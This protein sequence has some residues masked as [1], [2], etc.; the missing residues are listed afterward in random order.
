MAWR[1]WHGKQFVKT[2][3]SYLLVLFAG[4]LIFSCLFVNDILTKNREQAE[5]RQG[6]TSEN[7]A[8]L[9]DS[10]LENMTSLCG[11]ISRLHWVLKLQ[12]DA[13]SIDA[14]FDPLTRMNIVNDVRTYTSG[15]D[16]YKS[17]LLIFPQQETAISSIGWFELEDY[18]RYIKIKE[19]PLAEQ[20]AGAIDKHHDF[21]VLPT[22]EEGD[23]WLMKTL[24]RTAEPRAHL[25]FQISRSDL[26]RFLLQY[27]PDPLCRM[28]IRDGEG[29]LLITVDR[30]SR[31]SERDRLEERT[32]SAAS[33]DW[34]YVMSF[35]ASKLTVS[36]DS[37]FSL[38]LAVVVCCLVHPVLAY[39]LAS[40]SYR[41]L[42]R[43]LLKLQ[44]NGAGGQEN[45]LSGKVT[46]YQA[47]EQ[48]IDSLSVD[49]RQLR[50][51]ME[52]YQGSVQR[53]VLRQLLQ[54]YF[55]RASLAKRMEDFPF[56][57]T[58][59]TGF[60]VIIV[61]LSGQ[62]EKEEREE[63]RETFYRRRV[64]VILRMEQS[65]D[66]CGLSYYLLASYE[67]GIVII[68]YDNEGRLD[69][70]ALELAAE[71]MRQGEDPAS[72]SSLQIFIGPMER[73]MIGISKS[74]Q[75]A[76]EKLSYS[77][78]SQKMYQPGEFSADAPF[79]YPTDWEIQ[80]INNLK[81]AQLDSTQR[82]INEIREEN[83]RRELSPTACDALLHSLRNTLR[84]V[85]SELNIPNLKAD[86]EAYLFRQHLEE[87]SKG[88]ES[89]GSENAGML[90]GQWHWLEAG[91]RVICGRTSYNRAESTNISTQ[92]V[93]YVNLHF[94][95]PSISLKELAF[96]F[97]VS[98]STVSAA[99]K[100]VVGLNFYDY[101][102]RLRME[103]A[104]E[105]LRKSGLSIREICRQV[106]YEN[107]YSFRRA[108][109]RYEGI[110]PSEYRN[111]EKQESS[112]EGSC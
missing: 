111:K 34:K 12:A 82:I 29:N 77:A 32:V 53:D 57:F 71:K 6:E 76:K 101:V 7:I 69:D 100:P 86:V 90:E 65:L 74:Y 110:T 1:Q 2:F 78:F 72:Q 102:S 21:D 45:A 10:K 40:A 103:K 98:T 93:E 18:L 33:I 59:E 15:D 43:L 44:E 25:L 95:E 37:F 39:L 66:K 63:S 64:A 9:I 91:C 67:E 87:A 62:E 61:T 14:E 46:E 68:V 58:E 112:V 4:M 109:L 107:E 83:Q 27:F 52:E 48:H 88:G 105:L 23:I 28:E 55:D 94:S 47:I 8:S 16:F 26:K 35:N 22:G 30:P 41:P 3:L 81:T 54:G 75:I 104:K 11:K 97:N 70:S 36:A 84:R 38:A 56:A 96:Q 92:L 50:Q 89:A 80:L 73:G 79:Y 5:V 106:G 19:E 49:N 60:G 13:P 99:F 108:Y 51:R 24:Y 31:Y 42:Q 85:A 20:L 17:V